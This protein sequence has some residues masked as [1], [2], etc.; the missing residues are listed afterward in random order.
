MHDRQHAAQRQAA[1]RRDHV[2]LGDA[3][4]DEP[5]GQ[6]RL[7]CLDA[8]VRQQVAVH[9]HDVGARPGHPQE[10]IAIGE[11][12]LFG[13]PGRGADRLRRAGERQR[14]QAER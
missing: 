7:E 1:R 2:L 9:D 6:L 4:L 3:A 8:A 10:L 11:N 5:L 14:R 13:I 12:D